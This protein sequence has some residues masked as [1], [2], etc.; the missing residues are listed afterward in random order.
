MPHSIPPGPYYIVVAPNPG[1][2][3]RALTNNGEG[4]QLTIEYETG[5]VNQEWYI[6]PTD[7]TYKITPGP[8]DPA[9]VSDFGP[10]DPNQVFLLKEL[11]TWF[12]QGR[13]GTED[14]YEIVQPNDLIGVDRLLAVNE[15]NEKVIIKGFPVVREG[16]ERPAWKLI[17]LKKY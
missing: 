12:F 15:E 5:N 11:Q 7:D 10:I 9:C 3:Y 17:P 4:K 14:I 8:L 13:S 6:I 1:T 2:R 16:P